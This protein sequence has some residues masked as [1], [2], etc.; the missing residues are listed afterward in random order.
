MNLFVA[1]IVLAM[2]GFGTIAQLFL[3]ESYWNIFLI[4]VGV[5]MLFIVKGDDC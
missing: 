3:F 2:I 5:L 1:F 4:V